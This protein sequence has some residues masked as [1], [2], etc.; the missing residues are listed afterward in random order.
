MELPLDL[1]RLLAKDLDVEDVLALLQA[2]RFFWPLAYRLVAE[3]VVLRERDPRVSE[4]LSLVWSWDKRCTSDPVFL[5]VLRW[6]CR[7]SF[8]LWR[9]RWYLVV[10]SRALSQF[11]ALHDF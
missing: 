9:Q 1:V 10:C 4:R 11:A 7:S 5:V 6:G 8:L 2:S 3:L